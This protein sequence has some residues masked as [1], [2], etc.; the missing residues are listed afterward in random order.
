MADQS[1]VEN[2]LVGLIAAALYPNGPD[3]TSVVGPDCRIYRGWPQSASLD[4]DLAA[5]TINVTVFAKGEPGKNTTRYAQHWRGLPVTPALTVAVTGNTVSFGGIAMPGQV[6]GILADGHTYAYRIQNSDTPA[7]VAANLA[8]LARADW[9]V[10]QSGTTLSLVGAAHVVGRVVADCPA[11]KQARRQEQSFRV[12]CWC[13]TPATR[14]TVAIAIDQAIAVLRFID[15]PDGTQGRLLYEG[16]TEFD[17]S[18][19]ALL[20]RRDLL[21]TVEYPTTVTV[22]QP[23][24]LFGD[25]VLNAAQ[26]AV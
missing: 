10:Q 11:I 26:F 8:V 22:L 1:D 19:D 2:V 7:T 20:Y 24:M 23:R 6:A 25:L 12:T 17:Q 21:Y 14:D 9:T 16:T 15:L 5:G 4:T 13:P 3:G 18:Q